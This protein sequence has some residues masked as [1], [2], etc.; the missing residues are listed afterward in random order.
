MKNIEIFEAISGLLFADLYEQF[1]LPSDIDPSE[2]ALRLGDD[3]WNES[4]Q[5]LDEDGRDNAYI[6]HKSPSGLARPTVDWL[7]NSGFI[8]HR[9]FANGTFAKVCLTAK[10]LEAIRSETGREN[11]LLEAAK[12]AVEGAA[13]DTARKELQMVFSEIVAWSVRNTATLIHSTT[14]FGS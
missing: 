7:A 13:K 12:Q 2:L 14:G 11:R 4:L 5:P 1:P 10:G 3:Y 8:T 6:R 9:G